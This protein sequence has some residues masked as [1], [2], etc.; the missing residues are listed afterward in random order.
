MKRVLLGIL[1]VVG[2]LVGAVIMIGLLNLTLYVEASVPSRGELPDLP[3]GLSIENEF[4]GCGSGN[5][6]REFDVVGGSGDSAESILARLPEEECSAH[7]LIDR[8]PLCVGY[9]QQGDVVRG[10]VSLGKWSG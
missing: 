4:D 10:Y 7:S 3:S 1:G 9:R 5:C 2:V 8:R 6:Y